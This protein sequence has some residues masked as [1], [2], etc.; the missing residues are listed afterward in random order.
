MTSEVKVE[1]KAQ[2]QTPK[3]EQGREGK[4]TTGGDGDKKCLT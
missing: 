1:L 3:E 2:P 4:I